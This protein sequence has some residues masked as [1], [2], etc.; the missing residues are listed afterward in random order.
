MFKKAGDGVYSFGSRKVKMFLEKNQLKVRVGG[1][2]L[3]I[4]NFLDRYQVV[5]IDQVSR[6]TDPVRRMKQKLNAIKSNRSV[7]SVDRR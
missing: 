2:F 5:E 7:H 6:V 1:G 3:S 4:D